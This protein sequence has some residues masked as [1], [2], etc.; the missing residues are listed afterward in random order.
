MAITKNDFQKFERLM[1]S[2]DLDFTRIKLMYSYP[3]ILAINLSEILLAF[4]LRR[5][6]I[7]ERTHSNKIQME[8]SFEAE[9]HENFILRWLGWSEFINEFAPIS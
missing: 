8:C 1:S 9:N 7:S 5:G 6:A 3:E 4:L 2:I